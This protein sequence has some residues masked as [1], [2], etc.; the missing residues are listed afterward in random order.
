MSGL[1]YIAKVLIDSDPSG[2]SEPIESPPIKTLF[3]LTEFVSAA[4]ELFEGNG[5]TLEQYIS[6]IDAIYSGQEEVEKLFEL[7]CS[8]DFV[9]ACENDELRSELLIKDVLALGTSLP[10]IA[11]GPSD[12]LLKHAIYLGLHNFGAGLSTPLPVE[13]RNIIF[14]MFSSGDGEYVS[15]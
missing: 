13:F 2:V 11:T 6:V 3:G 5:L 10:P 4:D 7:H 14:H 9:L 1:K 12:E 15:Y 8:P